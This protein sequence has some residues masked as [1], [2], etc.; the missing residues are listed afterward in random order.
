MVAEGRRRRREILGTVAVGQFDEKIRR[1]DPESIAVPQPDGFLGVEGHPVDGGARPASEVPDRPS[2]LVVQCDGGV[3][4][5]GGVV[6][7]GQVDV[8]RTTQDELPPGSQPAIDPESRSAHQ[9]D[10]SVQHLLLL[11]L[12][13]VPRLRFA[14]KSCRSSSISAGPCIRHLIFRD[15]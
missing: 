5:A 9:G 12:I 10:S 2:A 13:P 1:A 14:D 7:N 3:S 4:A 8:A 11:G 15:S 6:R